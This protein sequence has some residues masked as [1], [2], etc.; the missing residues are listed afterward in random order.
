MLFVLDLSREELKTLCRLVGGEY[1]DCIYSLVKKIRWYQQQIPI[2]K[3]SADV[4][5]YQSYYGFVKLTD[6]MDAWY[7]YQ[8]T[9]EGHVVTLM[10]IWESGSSLDLA[11]YSVLDQEFNNNNIYFH[12]WVVEMKYFEKINIRYSSLS[13][14]LNLKCSTL[15]GGVAGLYRI[16]CGTSP[17][18][19]S[20]SKVYHTCVANLEFHVR[21]LMRDL[22]HGPQAIDDPSTFMDTTMNAFNESVKEFVEVQ[23]NGITETFKWLHN[24]PSFD[25]PY[26]S[27]YQPPSTDPSGPA[28]P[29]PTIPP[30][31]SP[32]SPPRASPTSAPPASPTS[33]PPTSPIP[34]PTS[35]VVKKPKSGND[36]KK[37]RSRH[38]SPTP[39]T[40]CFIVTWFIRIV[41]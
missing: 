9:Y 28:P 22:H 40:Y 6:L 35:P 8:Y 27:H 10:M 17:L 38:R 23:T 30:P 19:A 29:S 31:T 2:L 25:N 26:T 1:F 33:P 24:Y 41:T 4:N 39:C 7:G 14:F 20:N 12:K 32:T 21:E 15:F 18:T 13:L 3:A 5:L 16:L 37:R 11:P 34:S 36:E